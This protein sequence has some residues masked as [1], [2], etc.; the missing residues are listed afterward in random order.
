M[1]DK[2]DATDGDTLITWR[3]CARSSSGMKTYGSAS[4]A[5][6]ASL[7]K[8]TVVTFAGRQVMLPARRDSISTII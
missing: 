1:A 3:R 6:T 7:L 5:I 8:S 4:D 2:N